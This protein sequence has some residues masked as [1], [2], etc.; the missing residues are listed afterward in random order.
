M[1]STPSG[2]GPSHPS[3]SGGPVPSPG[4]AASPA[5]LGPDWQPGPD[6]LP[7]RRAARVLLVDEA[8]RL[9][10]VR[11]HDIDQPERSWWFT[12]GGGLEPGES[13]RQGAVREVFEETGLVVDA[14]A[15]IGPVLTRSA[16]FDFVAQRCRQDEEVFLARIAGDAVLASDGWTE[17]EVSVL[18][19]MRWWSLDELADVRIEVF[20]EGLA[21]LV[22]PLLT[23]WDGVTRHLGLQYD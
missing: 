1:N 22:R 9:L 13:P 21:D 17:L 15:L 10:L 16:I 12:V 18:D 20:P 5:G 3:G 11:G 2:S 8:D 23:G 19:E 14:D 7:Y 4:S 6:G